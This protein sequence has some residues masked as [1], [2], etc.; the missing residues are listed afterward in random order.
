M[1]LFSFVP[2][3]RLRSGRIRVPCTCAG[4]TKC[5]LQATLAVAVRVVQAANWGGN[6]CWTGLAVNRGANTGNRLTLKGA[7]V[8]C[9]VEI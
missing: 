3:R 7:G 5:S 9:E 1:K 2:A 6:S 4:T 8:T